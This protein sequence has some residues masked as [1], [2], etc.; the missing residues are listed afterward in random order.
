[1]VGTTLTIEREIEDARSTRDAGV[2][3]KRED[4]PSSSSGKR[5]NT[6][7]SHEFQDQGQDWARETGLPQRQ[8]SQDF[9]TTQSQL[10]VEHESIRLIPPRSSTGQRNRFQFRGAIQAL[11]AAQR[12]QRGQSVG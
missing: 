12:G 3:S 1:M 5:Q 11:S 7:A 4:Q 10:V 9:G 8:V 6:S 2:G